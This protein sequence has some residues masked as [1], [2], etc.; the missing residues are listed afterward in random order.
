MLS[1]NYPILRPYRCYFS[2]SSS[3]RSKSKT[4]EFSFRSFPHPTHTHYSLID[5]NHVHGTSNRSL[6]NPSCYR[7]YDSSIFYIYFLLSIVSTSQGCQVFS[8]F[9]F[10]VSPTPTSQLTTLLAHQ[11]YHH[12]SS[13]EPL[14]LA[15]TTSQEP[16][17][18]ANYQL[19][20]SELGSFD[21][22]N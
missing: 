20:R 16:L 2:S 22:H 10:L 6:Q 5:L 3:K 18:L 7:Q 9:V 19:I 14:E 21:N 15:T 12:T 8:S 17:L 1:Q 11:R 4:L 13:S